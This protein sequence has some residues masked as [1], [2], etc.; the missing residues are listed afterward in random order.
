MT[1]DSG[2]FRSLKWLSDLGVLPEGA[3][4]RDPR[5][6]ARLSVEGFVPLYEGKSVWLHDPYYLSDRAKASVSRFVE[7][8]QLEDAVGNDHW[9][10]PRLVFRDIASST[11][12]RT[13][14]CA[15]MP[16]GVHGNKLPSLD[17]LGDAADVVAAQLGSLVLDYVIRM[18]ITTAL[19]WFYVATLP[20]AEQDPQSAFARSVAR[21]VRGL[22]YL[23]AEYQ[24]PTTSPRVDGVERM[25]TRLM[26]D[27]LVADQY[28][29]ASKQFDH[30][31]RRFPIYDKHAE[32]FAYP[33]LAAQV[34]RAFCE[35]GN[36]AAE[37]KA[38]QLTKAR[39]AAG[40]SFGLDEVYVPDGG[41]AEANA[42]AR[43]ILEAG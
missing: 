1:S 31:A 9:M 15:V 35:G 32:A 6:R 13:L 14:V 43:A 33:K 42:E 30:I 22:N 18:K 3:D 37:A 16:P 29:L 12:Q 25:A 38:E 4:T 24:P 27:A 8:S 7:R 26:L 20:I 41:W 21:L 36:E 39:A 28:G 17:G 2:L 10:S 11:N 19:N 40:Y 34:Y 5:V 23:G